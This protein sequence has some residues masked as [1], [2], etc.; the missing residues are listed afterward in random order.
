[1]P[2]T[3]KKRDVREESMDQNIGEMQILVRLTKKLWFK[4][5]NQ[6]Q[7]QKEYGRVG[8]MTGE[9]QKQTD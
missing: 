6:L 5:V 4:I 7:E 9:S 2:K 3:L 8:K 1:M